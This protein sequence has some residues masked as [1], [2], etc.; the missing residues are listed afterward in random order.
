M[1][2]VT[3][4]T[5]SLMAVVYAV[6]NINKED[7]LKQR[8]MHRNSNYEKKLILIECIADQATRMST[9][10]LDCPWTILLFYSMS[11]QESPVY[12]CYGWSFI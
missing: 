10:S 11:K 7:Y 9:Q 8:L 3:R 1:L 12:Q 2:S 5:P 4:D 6:M